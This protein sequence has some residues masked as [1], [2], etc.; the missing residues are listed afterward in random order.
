MQGR[1]EPEEYGAKGAVF[2][3]KVFGQYLAGAIVFPFLAVVVAVAQVV[4][5]R[6]FDV[7]WTAGLGTCLV[8]AILSPPIFAAGAWFGYGRGDGRG[9]ILSE[10]QGDVVEFGSRFVAGA[11]AYGLQFQDV[12]GALALAFGTALVFT[13]VVR[14][15]S[16]PA[17]RRRE[18]A[19][20]EEREERAEKLQALAREVKQDIADHR[21]E[22]K[23]IMW[24]RGQARRQR[25]R[26]R[27]RKGR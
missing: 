8:I 16:H 7:D 24:E 15:W 25:R 27:Q 23:R 18:S 19:T 12:V 10:T 6:W 21:A 22:G 14:V 9:Q 26:R 13:L 5:S 2:A 3:V 20:P 4:A 17:A 11:V 1:L